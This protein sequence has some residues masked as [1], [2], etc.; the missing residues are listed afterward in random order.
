MAE[1]TVGQIVHY[2][3]R[4]IGASPVECRAAIVTL[5]W[6]DGRASVRVF[7]LTLEFDRAVHRAEH[8]EWAGQD[9]PVGTW[10]EAGH[11][12]EVASGEGSIVVRPR[13]V[14]E[15]RRLRAV[16]EDLAD[17]GLRADLTPTM[18]N[19]NDTGALYSNFARY[20]RRLDETL[21]DRARRALEAEA[22]DG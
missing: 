1:S 16:L 22:S 21:R 8:A 14:A 7:G 15:V 5:P 12:P 3:T 4:D 2:T 20:L 11:T 13:C 18:P 17:H 19:A 10:H 6:D 9:T